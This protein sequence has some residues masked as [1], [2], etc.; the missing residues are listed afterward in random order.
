M[1]VSLGN[2]YYTF[3]NNFGSY[4][5]YFQCS[6]ADHAGPGYIAQWQ[7]PTGTYL[8]NEPA[9]AGTGY[10]DAT[11]CAATTLGLGLFVFRGTRRHRT[12]G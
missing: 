11:G 12:G 7:T 9:A 8:L 4:R 6:P 3:T 2:G 10:D 5:I 1:G